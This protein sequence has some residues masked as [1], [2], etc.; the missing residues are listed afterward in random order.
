MAAERWEAD[1]GEAV[2][3]KEGSAAWERLHDRIAHRFGRVEVRA[4][5]KR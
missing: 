3:L 1:A 2:V 4:R 5:V